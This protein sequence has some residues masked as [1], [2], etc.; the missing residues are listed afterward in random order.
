MSK[1]ASLLD[2][3]L[4]QNTWYSVVFKLEIITYFNIP[5]DI[6]FQIYERYT[7]NY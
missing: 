5:M 4:L 7:R 1:I 6:F 2:H 3:F